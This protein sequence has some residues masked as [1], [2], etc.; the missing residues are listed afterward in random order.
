MSKI[1]A[2]E[3][4]KAINFSNKWKHHSK[5]DF[6]EKLKHSFPELDLGAEYDKMFGK[7]EIK[8]VD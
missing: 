7:T 1:K 3:S 2:K 4:V 5:E 6:I 8:N